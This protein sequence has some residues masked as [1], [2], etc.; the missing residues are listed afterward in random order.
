[1]L[2]KMEILAIQAIEGA[3][4]VKHSE[5]LV[6]VFRTAPNGMAGIAGSCSPWTDKGPHTI[7]WQRIIIG[8]KISLVGPPTFELA[9]FDVSESTKALAPL[10]NLTPVH[11][12]G[13]DEAAL[14]S[15]RVQREPIGSAALV[16]NLF[17]LGP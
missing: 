4:L 16:M 14:V 2:L 8:E 17:D 1:M 15:W 10:R 6:A 13:T 11:A 3:G 5:V 9:P 12:E 7:G